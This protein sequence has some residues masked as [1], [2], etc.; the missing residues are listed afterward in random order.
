MFEATH[1]PRDVP[2]VMRLTG[3]PGCSSEV[4]LFTENGPCSVNKDGKTT[5]PNK[6]SWNRVANV[7]YV[8]QPA[9]TG[10]SYGRGDSSIDNNEGEIS[11]DLHHFTQEF[12]K[13]YPQFH[14]N[15]FYVWGESY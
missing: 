15:D 11:E 5:T 6:H 3:G 1:K 10:F 7:I 2:V 13:R 14:K 12:V 9:D 4:A 8:D